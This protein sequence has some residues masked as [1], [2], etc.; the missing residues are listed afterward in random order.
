MTASRVASW[1]KKTENTKDGR[2]G[3]RCIN[4]DRIDVD[5]SRRVP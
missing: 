4:L 5:P 1:I 3:A 2:F